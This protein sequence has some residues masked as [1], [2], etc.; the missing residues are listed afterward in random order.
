MAAKK[1]QMEKLQM[2]KFFGY[3]KKRAVE[4]PA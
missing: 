1:S 4:N 3:P 2:Q